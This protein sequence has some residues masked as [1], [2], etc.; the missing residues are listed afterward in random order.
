M[1]IS[2]SREEAE[3]FATQCYSIRHPLAQRLAIRLAAAL[4]LESQGEAKTIADCPSR[5]VLVKLFRESNEALS[6]IV[7][8]RGDELSGDAINFGDL[9][10]VTAGFESW[11]AGDEERDAGGDF[12]LLIEECDPSCVALPKLMREELHGR[13]YEDVDVRCEW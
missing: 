12:V 1:N 6:H 10:V 2:L 11:V 5:D 9:H 13:G 8:N 4:A 3:F 7:Q